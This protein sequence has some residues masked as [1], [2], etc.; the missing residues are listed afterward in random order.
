LETVLVKAR[1]NMEEKKRQVSYM[2]Q[3]MNEQ[4]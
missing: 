2:R 1:D 4:D 3:Q